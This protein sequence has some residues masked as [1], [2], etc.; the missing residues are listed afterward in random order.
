MLSNLSTR[1]LLV[2]LVI[3]IV[4]A[5]AHYFLPASNWIGGGQNKMDRT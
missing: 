1:S 4:A 2:V 3:L 5:C